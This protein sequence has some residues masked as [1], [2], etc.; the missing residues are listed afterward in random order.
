LVTIKPGANLVRQRQYPIPL[1]ARKGIAHNQRLRNQGILREVKSA[2]NTPLLPVK[3][4]GSN[5]YQPVQDLCQ[6]NKATETICPVVPNPYPL[7]SLIPP[8]AGAF[9]CLD[10]K[11]AFFCLGLVEASQPLFAFEWENPDTGANG[12][13]TWSSFHRASKIPPLSLG[14]P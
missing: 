12:Q 8:T 10:L 3:K 5:N 4:P 1:K 2:W 11:D 7:P 6:V 9:T 14:K 13:L